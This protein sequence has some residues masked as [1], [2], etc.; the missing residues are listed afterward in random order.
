LFGYAN[1]GRCPGLY[2]G[3]P[4]GAKGIP[5]I[6]NAHHLFRADGFLTVDNCII[7][8][9]TG[10]AITIIRLRGELAGDPDFN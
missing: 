3:C 5:H 8:Q 7:Y 9:M 1:P 4:L 2:Y 6:E 10:F